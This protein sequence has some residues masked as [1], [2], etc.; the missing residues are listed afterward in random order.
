MV[1]YIL[2][3]TLTFLMTHFAEVT[4]RK[5]DISKNKWTLAGFLSLIAGI[6][7][8]IT[9]PMVLRYGIG[10]DYFGDLS[11]LNTYLETGQFNQIELLTRLF[12]FTIK[13]CNLDPH[14]YFVFFAIFTNIGF[15][16]AIFI[17]KDNK[18]MI[19]MF[20]YMFYAIYFSSYNQMRQSFGIAYG[21]L[22]FSIF[23]NYRGLRSF[24]IALLVSIFS[25]MTHY[26][27]IINVFIIL[28]LYGVRHYNHK[29]KMNRL[30]IFG[31]AFVLISPILMFLFREIIEYIPFLSKYAGYLTN[32]DYSA[33][34]LTKFFGTIGIFTIPLIMLIYF[35]INFKNEND[36]A[37][38]KIIFIYLV[39]SMGFFFISLILNN[40]MLADRSRTLI[41]G[42]ELIS[43]PYLLSKMEGNRK[44]S[45]QGIIMSL[46]IIVTIGTFVVARLYPYK[47]IINKDL[48]IY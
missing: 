26:S 17:N 47:T 27:E 4:K 32:V 25:M 7:I 15:L 31:F 2:V 48:I 41:Y 40:L 16:S 37:I 10:M 14:F 13:E 3:Y 1:I 5:Y 46:M 34:P 6:Y 24:I 18:F 12:A 38:L 33:K 9:L 28:I 39:S 35:I 11:I 42:F 22:A 20:V 8:V 23:Y 44:K 21:C 36:D 30:F 43:F 45:F 29:I 19:R